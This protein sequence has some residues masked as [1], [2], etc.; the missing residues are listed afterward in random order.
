MI[1]QNPCVET[2]PDCAGNG[3]QPGGQVECLRCTGDGKL[4][5]HQMA[6][7]GLQYAKGAIEKL[8]WMA[9]NP[10]AGILAGNVSSQ[11]ESCAQS[12][13]FEI[14]YLRDKNIQ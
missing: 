2:C 4:F 1:K 13:Q 11:L 9:Q 14:N 7:D 6:P 5:L 8:R 3:F 12:I 10:P